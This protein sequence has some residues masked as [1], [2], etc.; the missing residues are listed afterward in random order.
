MFKFYSVLTSLRINFCHNRRFF[1]DNWWLIL[2]KTHREEVSD[3]LEAR[4][5]AK[6]FAQ[7]DASQSS[8]MA[9]KYFLIF[10]LN[11]ENWRFNAFYIDFV[12]IF[13]VFSRFEGWSLWRLWESRRFRAGYRR[14]QSRCDFGCG[15]CNFYFYVSNLL[16]LSPKTTS[17]ARFERYMQAFPSPM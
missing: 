1:I 13:V 8:G 10:F 4:Q 17:S 16:I 2:N 15:R 9:V 14:S 7:E 12:V 5:Q 11:D 6:E 3:D